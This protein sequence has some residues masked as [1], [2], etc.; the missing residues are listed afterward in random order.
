MNTKSEKLAAP[1]VQDN[2]TSAAVI[3][4]EM[5][6]IKQV[7]EVTGLK[8]P[9]LY[10]LIQAGRF[11]RGVDLLGTGCAVGWTRESVNAWLMER[12]AESSKAAGAQ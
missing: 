9:T 12:I 3:P 6:R 1:A 4:L 11:P 2:K 10:K 8:R 5:L 7:E